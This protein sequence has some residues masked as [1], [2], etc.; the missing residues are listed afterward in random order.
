MTVQEATEF[1]LGGD[2]AHDDDMPGI[3][4]VGCAEGSAPSR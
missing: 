3:I 4:R 2:L 1:A